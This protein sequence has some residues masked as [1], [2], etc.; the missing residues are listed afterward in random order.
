MMNTGRTGVA[1][2]LLLVVFAAAYELVSNEIHKR[3]SAE[4]VTFSTIASHKEGDKL[5]I[6]GRITFGSS[7]TCNSSGICTLYLEPTTGSTDPNLFVVLW[8]AETTPR[9]AEPNS[10]YLPMFFEDKSDFRLYTDDGRELKVEDPVRITGTVHKVTHEDGKTSVYIV[11][12]KA[13]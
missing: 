5:S 11:V 12:E 4:P 6:E 2:V 10:F 9:Q 13:E 1:L 7:V 8:M 3:R